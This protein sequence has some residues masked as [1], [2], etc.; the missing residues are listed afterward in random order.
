MQ[1]HEQMVSARQN[2]QR[3]IT[4]KIDELTKKLDSSVDYKRNLQIR[5]EHQKRYDKAREFVAK[6]SRQRGVFDDRHEKER[7]EAIALK[8]A[9]NQIPD[10]YKKEFD[11][12][13]GE[14]K[15]VS[16]PSLFRDLAR[17]SYMEFGWS[18]VSL[19]VVEVTQPEF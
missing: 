10:E 18:P 11:S 15:A 14:E 5:K 6:H 17:M 12:K 8:V 1:G 2:A 4:A 3:V 16:T 9:F 19:H 7:E 13:K